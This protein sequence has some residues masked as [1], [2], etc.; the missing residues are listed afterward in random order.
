MYWC[1][2]V[3]M[4]RP[5]S[6]EVFTVRMG[7]HHAQETALGRLIVGGAEQI[8]RPRNGDRQPLGQKWRGQTNVLSIA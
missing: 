3:E 1:P 8:P 5:G 6:A 4:R 7:I 2:A